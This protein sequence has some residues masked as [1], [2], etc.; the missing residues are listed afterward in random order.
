MNK[1]FLITGVSTALLL[2][3]CGGG[4]SSSS[5]EQQGRFIDSAVK[6][7]SYTCSSGKTGLTDSNGGFSCPKDDTV[8]FAVGGIVLGTVAMQGVITPYTLQT[9]SAAALDIAQ[10]LQT[11]DEDGNAENG[12]QI[13]HQARELAATCLAG[14]GASDFDTAAAACIGV[15]LIS[16]GQAKAHLQSTLEA[17]AANNISAISTGDISVAGSHYTL[18][19]GYPESVCSATSMGVAH[20]SKCGTIGE[21][22]VT[23]V[24]GNKTCNDSPYSSGESCHYFDQS[25]IGGTGTCILTITLD[26][27]SGSGSESSDSSSSSSTGSGSGGSKT[28]SVSSIALDDL[29]NTVLKTAG[30]EGV[31]DRIVFCSDK[32]FKM[33]GKANGF[34]YDVIGTWSVSG[35]NLNAKFTTMSTPYGTQSIN[36]SDTASVPGGIISNGTTTFG[37]KITSIEKVANPNCSL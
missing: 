1:Q 35:S 8:T 27:P 29:D 31:A 20:N 30:G 22:D 23:Y 11:L 6:G 28:G 26:T 12:L 33:S 9:S 37:A 14:P 19:Y 32:T 36:D 24:S 7:V 13:S 4:S 25:M 18:M 10:L 34:D 21:C 2:A 15:G 17:E 16:E 3:A 5:G